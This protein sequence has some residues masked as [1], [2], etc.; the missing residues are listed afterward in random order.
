M[1]TVHEVSKETGVSIRTLHYYDKIGLLSPDAVSE[2]GYRLYGAPALA[3]LGQILFFRA[4]EFP[5]KEIKKILDAPNFDPSEALEQQISLLKLRREHF[6]RLL[7][8]ALELREKGGDAMDF[9]TFDT[10]KMDRY[11]EE[12]KKRWQ[13][14]EAYR[15]YQTKTKNYSAEDQ[16]RAS[17]ELSEQFERFSRLLGTPCEAPEVQAE[18]ELL[19]QVITRNYYTCTDEILASLGRMYTEDERFRSY[20]D[21]FAP[22]TADFVG[23]AISYYCQK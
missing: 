13:D 14:T 22:G 3:R 2:A 17:E 19:K 23:K 7:T 16:K 18:V 4:L 10:S 12:V 21:R 1:K 9:N 11:A 8:L 20:L 6:D 5:L 15:E